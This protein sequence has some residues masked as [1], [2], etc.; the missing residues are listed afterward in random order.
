[1][2]GPHGDQNRKTKNYYFFLLDSDVDSVKSF[3]PESIVGEAS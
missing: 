1:M 2:E 3:W